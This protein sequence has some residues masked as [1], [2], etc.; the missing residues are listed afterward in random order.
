M[1]GKKEDPPQISPKSPNPFGPIGFGGF[2]SVP[3]ADVLVGHLRFIDVLPNRTRHLL[4]NRL[5]FFTNS[6]PH[7]FGSS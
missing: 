1:E 6:A 2:G 7:Q 5:L 4:L 3:F